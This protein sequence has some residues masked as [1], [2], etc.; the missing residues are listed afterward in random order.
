M[1]KDSEKSKKYFEIILHLLSEKSLLVDSTN[2]CKFGRKF[3][4]TKPSK[5][6]YLGNYNFYQRLGG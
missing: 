3:I 6:S 1:S 4:L 2:T 5:I